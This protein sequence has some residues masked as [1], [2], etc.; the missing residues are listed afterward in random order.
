MS[1]SPDKMVRDE[2]LTSVR[3]RVTQVRKWR[4]R[5]ARSRLRQPGQGRRADAAERLLKDLRSTILNAP[6]SGASS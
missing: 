1:A 6:I 4:Y 5:Q 3:E 2:E